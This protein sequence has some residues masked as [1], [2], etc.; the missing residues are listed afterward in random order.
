[1]QDPK[2]VNQMLNGR[3]PMCIAADYNQNEVI[4]FLIE[5]GGDVNVSYDRFHWYLNKPLSVEN[6]FVTV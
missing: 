1:M 2:I 3:Y 5:K 4:E 6:S